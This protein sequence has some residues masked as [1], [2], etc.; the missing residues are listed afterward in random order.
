[1]IDNE[2]DMMVREV[3]QNLSQQGVN[4]ELYQQITGKTLDDIKADLRP[5]A[6]KRVKIDLILSQIAREESLEATQEELDEQIKEIASYY[7]RKEE[8]IKQLF[9]EN[10]DQL[11]GDIITKKAVQLVKDNLK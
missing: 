11:K 2:V 5:Q 9:A 6:E 7:G 10:M 3:E 4:M 1:M 8:E